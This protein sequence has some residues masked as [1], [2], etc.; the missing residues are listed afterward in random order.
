MIGTLAVG[1]WAIRP[2]FGT[3]RRGLGRSRPRPVPS[4]L[5]QMNQPTHQRPAYQLRIIRCG[6]IMAVAVKELTWHAVQASL[7]RGTGGMR[8][9]E[10]SAS[11][12]APSVV[13]VDRWL[14]EKC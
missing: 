12:I 10:V 2:T 13:K 9:L 8:I 1:W 7:R 3:S 5:Y 4:S 14:C 11:V 6:T